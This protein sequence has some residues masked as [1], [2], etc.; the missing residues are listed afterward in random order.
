MLSIAVVNLKGGSTKTTSAAYL[1]HAL[2]ESGLSV[3]GV[4][5]DPENCSLVRWSDLASWEIPVVGMPVKDLHRRLSSIADGF[6]AVVIDTPPMESGRG[7]VT[8]AVRGASH[9]VVPM[10]PT[11][12]DFDR[13]R[14]VLDLIDDIDPLRGQPAAV[15]VLLTRVITNSAS[16]DVYRA[17]A[18]DLV[19]V[20]SA[21]VSRLERFAQAFGNPIEN[22]LNTGYGD[23]LSEL[24]GM[25]DHQP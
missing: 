24:L 17:A 19:P 20:L 10:S 9:I 25:E 22:A 15:A 6:D 5:A 8:S 14:A 2:A 11:P 16:V 1:L 3:L 7:I 4:D 13:L 18:R 12:M 23:A 21:R